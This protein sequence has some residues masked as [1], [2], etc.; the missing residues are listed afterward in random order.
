MAKI[1]DRNGIEYIPH[2]IF[3]VNGNNGNGRKTREVDFV[4]KEW[5]KPYWSSNPI[6]AIEVKGWLALSDWER[7]KELEAINISTFIATAPIIDFWDKEG[8]I[9]YKIDEIQPIGHFK[10]N[11]KN[12]YQQRM[13]GRD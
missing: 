4:L 13:T 3:E 9:E 2:V 5:I 12:K 10:Q 8:F 7:R 1:L 11:N 6:R